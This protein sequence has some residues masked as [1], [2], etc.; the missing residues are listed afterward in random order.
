MIELYKQPRRKT[1]KKE[2]IR[3]VIVSVGVNVVAKTD[4]EMYVL[5]IIKIY[6]SFSFVFSVM[7]LKIELISKVM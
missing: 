1:T 7:P 3:L 5:S 6:S 2:H 4:D